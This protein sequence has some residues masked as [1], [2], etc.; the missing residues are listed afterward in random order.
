VAILHFELGHPLPHERDFLLGKHLDDAFELLEEA[1][2]G[3]L[4]FLELVDGL[5]THTVFFMKVSLL[6]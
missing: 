1:L 4:A 5:P 2:V 6:G 3:L